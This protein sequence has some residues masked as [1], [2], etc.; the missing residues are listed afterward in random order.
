M[1]NR[2]H[3]LLMTVSAVVVMRISGG[4]NALTSNSTTEA[5]VSLS[6]TIDFIDCWIKYLEQD[7]LERS[8]IY[9]KTMECM[10][11]KIPVKL[12]KLLSLK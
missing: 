10:F 5:L 1:R 8:N 4:G 11:Q 7:S 2:I 9:F 3:N 6:A 12:P